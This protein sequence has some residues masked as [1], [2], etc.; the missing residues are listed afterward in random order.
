MHVPHLALLIHLQVRRLDQPNSSRKRMGFDDAVDDAD[1]ADA[2]EQDEPVRPQRAEPTTRTQRQQA[3]NEAEYVDEDDDEDSVDSGSKKRRPQV[4]LP[5][6]S[7]TIRAHRRGT[8]QCLPQPTDGRPSMWAGSPTESGNNRLCIWQLPNLSSTRPRPLQPD[9]PYVPIT[10]TSAR[11]GRAF[12]AEEACH[13]SADP[14]TASGPPHA[15]P[16]PPPLLLSSAC[17]GNFSR[18]RYRGHSSLP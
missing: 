6:I 18:P 11:H 7:I 5:S 2:S 17:D 12:T 8:Q 1:A 15:P 16:S 10:T 9:V 14:L 13:A 4:P 3:E